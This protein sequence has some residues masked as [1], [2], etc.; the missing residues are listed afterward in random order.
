MRHIEVSGL[1]VGASFWGLD[2]VVRRLEV[3]WDGALRAERELAALPAAADL[4]K[5]LLLRAHNREADALSP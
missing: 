5:Q 4:G 2:E 3:D 1:L